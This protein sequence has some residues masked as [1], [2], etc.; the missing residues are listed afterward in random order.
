MDQLLS[1][2]FLCD[3]HHFLWQFHYFTKAKLVIAIIWYF[4]LTIPARLPAKQDLEVQF[5][6]EGVAFDWKYVT[7]QLQ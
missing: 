6:Q 7:L 2:H 4:P 3:L 1:K 5:T